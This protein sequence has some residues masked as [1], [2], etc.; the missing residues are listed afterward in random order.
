[1]MPAIVAPLGRLNRPRTRICFECARVLVRLAALR[2]DTL[3]RTLAAERAL[4]ARAILRLGMTKAPSHYHVSA[5]I[6][7]PQA[8]QAWSV[9]T[10]HAPFDKEVERNLASSGQDSLIGFPTREPPPPKAKA[11]IQLQ[12]TPAQLKREPSPLVFCQPHR[13]SA[14]RIGRDA[15]DVGIM[16]LCAEP[17]QRLTQLHRARACCSRKREENSPWPPPM[18]LLYT[19]ID[20][21]SMR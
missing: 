20:D 2:R 13:L 6:A 7:P 5:H 12:S 4:V 18:P 19:C 15:R 11:S 10:M 3:D 17:Q 14:F 16:E 8:G 21:C 9:T 1:M